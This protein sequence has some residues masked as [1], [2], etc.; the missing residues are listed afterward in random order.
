[1]PKANQTLPGVVLISDWA[2]V[3]DPDLGLQ[4]Q[5]SQ[6]RSLFLSRGPYFMGCKKA[7]ADNPSEAGPPMHSGKD[8]HHKKYN[9]EGP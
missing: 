2:D 1:M 6:Y 7:Q 9:C 5:D 4:L 8:L 3:G